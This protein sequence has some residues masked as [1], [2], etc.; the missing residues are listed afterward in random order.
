MVRLWIAVALLLLP[1]AI[2]ADDYPTRP[3]TM[4]VAAA[5]GGP[6]DVLARIMAE[7]MTP[8]LGQSVVVENLGGGGGVVGAQRVVRAQPDGYTTLL[9][10]VATYA[11]PPLYGKEAPYN[12]LTDFVDVALIA[13]IPLILIA[14]KDF[15]AESVE[16][17]VAYAKANPGKLNYGSA[18][19]V[20]RASRLRD[21]RT[22]DRR[23][24]ST[25]ALPRHGA[26]D[27]GFAGRQTRFHLRYCRD[28][29]SKYKK[30]DRQ[31]HRQSF[32]LPLFPAAATA[33]NGREGI[34]GRFSVDLGGAVPAEGH[35]GR[36][37]GETQCSRRQYDKLT[38]PCR[39]TQRSCGD[40]RVD[41]PALT[42]LSDGVCEERMGQV[43]SDH[44]RQRERRDPI[45]V[46]GD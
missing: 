14:R 42:S 26:S 45:I 4:V 31:R 32:R 43:G 3:V 9:G 39:A 28:R 17:F 23:P 18:G 16:D 20:G 35:T 1:T 41:R 15:P 2:R 22:R 5:A 6:I 37:R 27:A 44:S 13:E 21:A 24:V 33:N 11:N 10:T 34:P 30:W 25:R 19:S 40:T 8:S 46:G 36:A 7:R 29:G 38:R 12:P